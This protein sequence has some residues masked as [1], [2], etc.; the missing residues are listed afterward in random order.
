MGNAAVPWFGPILP[1]RNDVD[2]DDAAVTATTDV[3]IVIVINAATA[4]VEEDQGKNL[5][6]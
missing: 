6:L 2:D 1:K 4:S 3:T 5:W